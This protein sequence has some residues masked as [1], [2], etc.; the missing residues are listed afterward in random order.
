MAQARALVAVAADHPFQLAAFGGGNLHNAIP[1]EAGALVVCDA[2]SG[3]AVADAARAELEAIAAEYRPAEPDLEIRVAA[4]SP[5]AISAIQ[6]RLQ[7]IP[8]RTSCPHGLVA[9]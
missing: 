8:R 2:E 6:N 1:R 3:R 4:T 9:L 7:S 5:P